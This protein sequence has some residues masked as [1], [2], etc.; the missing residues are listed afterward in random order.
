MI[1]YIKHEYYLKSKEP[2]KIER[3]KN[4]KTSNY[5][6]RIRKENPYFLSLDIVIIKPRD[7]NRNK[8]IFKLML[9]HLRLNYNSYTFF[10][11]FCLALPCVPCM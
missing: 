4:H 11:G 5:I 6:D 7:E 1:L 10:F 3:N 8:N 9:E 2:R